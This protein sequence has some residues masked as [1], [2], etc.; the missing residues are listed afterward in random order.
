MTPTE[1][2]EILRSYHFQYVH[3]SKLMR[4]I[5]QEMGMGTMAFTHKAMAGLRDKR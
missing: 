5:E 3:E 2:D 4:E 1:R